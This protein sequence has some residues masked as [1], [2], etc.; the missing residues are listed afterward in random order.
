[1]KKT[2]VKEL[3]PNKEMQMLMVMSMSMQNQIQNQEFK[4]IRKN[5]YK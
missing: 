5:E 3:R 4:I 2:E 1:M